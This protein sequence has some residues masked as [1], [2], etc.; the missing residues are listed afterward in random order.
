[1]NFSLRLKMPNFKK[2]LTG[3]LFFC[4]FQQAQAQDIDGVSSFFVG[5]VSMDI[6]KHNKLLLYGG[7]S[8]SDKIKAFLVLP[9]FK[10]NK[11]LTLTP[12]YTYVNID[13]DNGSKLV[14]HQFLG[15]ATLAFPIAKNWTLADRNMYFYRFRTDDDLSFYRNRLGIIHKTELFKKQVSI[16][17]HDEIYLNLDNGRFTRNRV[18]LGGDIKLLKWLTPQVMFMYQSDRATGN[19]ILGWLIFTVPLE[20]LGIF[21]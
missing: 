16:F 17:L 10:I 6:P 21:K 14:E 7:F 12:G 15:M 2:A 1:M 8:P 9:N 20:N 4:V 19:K 18:V 5:G 13:L 11:Y 3:F